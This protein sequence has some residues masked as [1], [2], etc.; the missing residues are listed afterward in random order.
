MSF[1]IG[2]SY[3]DRDALIS[4]YW[5][6]HPRFLFLKSIRNGA[7]LAD[8]GAGSGGL[9]GWKSWGSPDRRDLKMYAADLSKGEFFD[10]YEDFD[11]VDLGKDRTKF[12]DRV[13]DSAIL[14]HVIEHVADRQHLSREVARITKPGAKIYIEWPRPE[15]GRI[16]S[17]SVLEPFGIACSTL[18]FFDDATHLEL[19]TPAEAEAAFAAAGFVRIASGDVINDFLFPELFRCGLAQRDSEATTYAL[20]LAFRFSCY[21]IMEKA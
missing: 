21:L 12:P 14:S 3:R 2:G 8:L 10:R 15:S 4:E 17:R 16:I 9:I 6:F 1:D 19:I 11:L 5:Q 7:R 18:N 13:F 20:W